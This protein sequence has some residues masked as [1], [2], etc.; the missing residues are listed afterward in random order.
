LLVFASIYGPTLIEM[1]LTWLLLQYIRMF[2][3]GFVPAGSTQ[4]QRSD[5]VYEWMNVIVRN[6]AGMVSAHLSNIP[7]SSAGV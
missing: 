1:R 2:V 5:M 6:S 7:N 4:L 3:E